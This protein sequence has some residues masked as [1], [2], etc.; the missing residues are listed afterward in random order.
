MNGELDRG[1]GK[2]GASEGGEGRVGCAVGG[3]P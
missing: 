2:R 1:G 3:R